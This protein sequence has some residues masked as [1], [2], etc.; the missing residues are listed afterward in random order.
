MKKILWVDSAKEQGSFCD[1]TSQALYQNVDSF[2]A[3]VTIREAESRGEN[4]RAVSEEVNNDQLN[5]RFN[6][7]STEVN[8]QGTET[9][10]RHRVEGV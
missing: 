9:P 8:D 6:L 7:L 4:V 3:E 10:T 5:Q 2:T 1:R